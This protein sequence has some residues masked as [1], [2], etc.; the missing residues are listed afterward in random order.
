[1]YEE[2]KNIF[3]LRKKIMLLAM[4]MLVS[5]IVS[6][7]CLATTEQRN[8]VSG[9]SFTTTQFSARYGTY[10]QNALNEI[11]E[12]NSE[13]QIASLTIGP[14]QLDGDKISI[15]ATVKEGDGLSNNLMATGTLYNSCKT[16]SGI[17]SIVGVLTDSLDNY[18]ILH[19]EIYNDTTEDFFYSNEAWRGKPH[20][21]MYLL[22]PN[23]DI[24]LFETAIPEELN[25]IDITNSEIPNA[26]YDGAWFIPFVPYDII[27]T[28]D[29]A[30]SPIPKDSTWRYYTFNQ[31][32]I[33][34]S[35][36][37]SPYTF[38]SQAKMSHIC[39]NAAGR[40]D[41]EIKFSIDSCK[42]IIGG[43]EYDSTGGWIYYTDISLKLGAGQYTDI[44]TA[45]LSGTV[46]SFSSGGNNDI[47]G[48]LDMTVDIA[49]VVFDMVGAKFP[50]PASLAVSAM[51]K[52]LTAPTVGY[53]DI[54]LNGAGFEHYEPETVGTNV[55]LPP[56]LMLMNTNHNVGVLFSVI[57]NDF[58]D[59]YAT[60][61]VSTYA[62]VR[63]S[64]TYGIM[65]YSSFGISG[66]DK[67]TIDS[68][69]RQ[70]PY[71]IVDPKG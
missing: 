4:I 60:D 68:G 50:V 16:Q 29:T 20:L 10:S 62:Y 66:T 69:N 25:S 37:N 31:V 35:I 54:Q 39:P 67:G 3:P 61:S 33:V 23:D 1:M 6:S 49:Q 38:V 27:E 42:Q 53:Q 12:D 9:Y 40:Q 5:L 58:K 8:Q 18:S 45:K 48:T 41:F 2:T 30:Q 70:D 64:A 55:V 19:F 65:N 17:N 59:P 71:V 13:P 44:R 11:V 15:W 51:Q 26:I 21:K 22:S 24:L 7:S 46:C 43:N 28:D 34:T 36:N 56:E 14:I 32:R 47:S 63:A 52:V 57:Y